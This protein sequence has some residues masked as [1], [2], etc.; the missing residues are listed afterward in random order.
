MVVR[1][2][3]KEIA[4]EQCSDVVSV[5][6]FEVRVMK[7]RKK[8]RRFTISATR[9]APE[10]RT[11]EME[12]EELVVYV[13]RAEKAVLPTIKEMHLGPGTAQFL[14]AQQTQVLVTGDPRL[15]VESGMAIANHVIALWQEGYY[16]PGP[17]YP[18]TLQE[19]LLDIQTGPKAKGNYDACFQSFS[20]A[21]RERPRGIGEVA[22]GIVQHPETKLWQIWLIID[23]PATFI[24]AY[25]DPAKAQANLETII[26]GSRKSGNE[27]KAAVLYQRVRLQADGEP[28]QLPYDMMLYLVEHLDRYTIKL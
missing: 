21:N 11:I 26:S 9:Q 10:I 18:Y 2:R 17:D 22:G 27:A 12:P 14:L 8:G 13:R 23:G 5:Q 4:K 16:K 6:Q 1:L 3:V 25:R 24:A 28:K 20:P 15:T 7:K 19:T